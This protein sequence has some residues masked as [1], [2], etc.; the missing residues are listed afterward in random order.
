[1][2]EYYAVERNYHFLT[3]VLQQL[4]VPAA[5]LHWTLAASRS[6]TPYKQSVQ[7]VSRATKVITPLQANLWEL[8]CL[9]LTSTERRALATEMIAK[10][11]V[12]M[13]KRNIFRKKKT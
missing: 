6:L 5:V 3:T 12:R 11:A 1:M 9:I 10:R 4:A 8:D 13:D 2:F 7:S